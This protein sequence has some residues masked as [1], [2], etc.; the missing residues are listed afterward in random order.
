MEEHPI[1]DPAVVNI[2]M[3]PGSS[4]PEQNIESLMWIFMIGK[5]MKVMS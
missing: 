1:R 2:T 3:D 4:Q 5:S